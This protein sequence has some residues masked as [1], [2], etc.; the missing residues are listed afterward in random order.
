MVHCAGAGGDLTTDQQEILMATAFLHDVLELRPGLKVDDLREAIRS[1]LTE[2][3]VGKMETAI[4]LTE[5]LTSSPRE[6]EE[7]TFAWMVRKGTDFSIIYPGSM[8]SPHWPILRI[9]KA[10]DVLAN[11]EETLT[12]LIEGRVDHGFKYSLADRLAVFD[13]RIAI[14]EEVDPE[15]PLLPLLIGVSQELTIELL[16]NPQSAE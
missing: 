11:L 16:R 6:G 7:D 13:M 15:N 12:D 4:S 8:N 5:I 10:A 2:A 3:D 1:Y 9:A 14:I